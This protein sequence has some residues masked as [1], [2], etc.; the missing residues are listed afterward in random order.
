MSEYNQPVNVPT[1][2][3]SLS[4]DPNT[5]KAGDLDKCCGTP[6]VSMGDPARNDTKTSGMKQR[7]S[8]AATKGFTSRGPMA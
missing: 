2:D 7:G 5:L 4:T 8:G 3:I 6:R 1:P